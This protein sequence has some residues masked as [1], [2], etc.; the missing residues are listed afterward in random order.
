[1]E[2]FDFAYINGAKLYDYDDDGTP[3]DAKI[4]VF[5][6]KSGTLKANMPYLI[7]AKSTGTKTITVNGAT[8]YAT[9]ENSI[10]CSTTALKFTFTGGYSTLG[11]DDIGG[12]YLLGG[13]TWNPVEEGGTMK[14][15][16]FY[17]KIESRDFQPFKAPVIRMT[18]FGEDDE[19]TEIEASP[20]SSPEGKEIIFD[21]QGHEV[22]HPEKG[23]YIRLLFIDVSIYY[24]A[25]N[26]NQE[27]LNGTKN[28]IRVNEQIFKF[29]EA[30]QEELSVKDLTFH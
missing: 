29:C 24:S 11:Y 5:K 19:T 6:S 2:E 16:R 27:R 25:R 14:P 1:M 7:R 8:L 10:D 23:I 3:D 21:L 22:E 13:G 12:S 15:M 20:L 18:V 17:L 28:V 4:E 9:A 30:K 26:K